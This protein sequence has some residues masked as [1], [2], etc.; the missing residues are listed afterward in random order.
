MEVWQVPS[1]ATPQ[2]VGSGSV[3]IAGLA[4]RNLALVEHRI[5]KR[6]RAKSIEVPGL[7]GVPLRRPI[8][9][10]LALNLG[11]LFRVLAP[12]RI[13]DNIR[14]VAQ[15][16]EEMGREEAAYWLG[17]AMHRRNPRRVLTALRMLLTEARVRTTTRR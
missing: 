14:A 17:M 6:L 11:L 8:D 15:G 4:G 7:R 1:R 3:R 10:D 9:E 12:M 5:L 13:H 16:I 2:L